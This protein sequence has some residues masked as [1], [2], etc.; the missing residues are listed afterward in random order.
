MSK[1]TAVLG[2][3]WRLRGTL[4]FITD[5]FA[6]IG[7]AILLGVSDRPWVRYFACYSIA[8]PLYCGPGLNEICKSA[9]GNDDPKRMLT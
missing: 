2:D 3:K 1:T 8:I 9:A 4:L 6:V 7:Y 5:I